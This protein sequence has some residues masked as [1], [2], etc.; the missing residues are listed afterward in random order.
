MI[1]A[2]FLFGKGKNIILCKSMFVINSFTSLPFDSFAL[3]Q[4]KT[5]RKCKEREDILKQYLDFVVLSTIKLANGTWHE[6]VSV[7]ST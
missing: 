6:E 1:S 7:K 4:T 5:T 3:E 2:K